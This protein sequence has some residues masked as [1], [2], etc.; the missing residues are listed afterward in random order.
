VPVDDEAAL[1]QAILTVLG[2]EALRHRLA[3]GGLRRAQDFAISKIIPQYE[4]LFLELIS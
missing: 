4:K 3:Q 2:D 1:A